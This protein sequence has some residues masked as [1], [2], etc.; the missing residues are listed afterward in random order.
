MSTPAKAAPIAETAEPP[1]Q[2]KPEALD[3]L[4]A[5]YLAL[6]KE[7]E[8]EVAALKKKLEP[9]TDRMEELRPKFLAQCVAYGSPHE[10]KSKLLS[11][12]D[13]E[14]MTTQSSSS[15]LDQAAIG[16]FRERCERLDRVTLFDELFEQVSEYRSRP[17]S[18]EVVRRSVGDLMTGRLAIAFL[19]CTIVKNNP[20]RL[21]AVRPRTKE[22]AA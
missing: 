11:G 8:D 18:A 12:L 19:K 20:P 14:V 2:L 7:V 6:D 3:A 15:S 16:T 21:A 1:K 17:G 5:E 10:K 13:Y 9:K 4:A 22:P